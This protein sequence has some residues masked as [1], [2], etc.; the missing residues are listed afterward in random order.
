M[1]IEKSEY[2][3]GSWFASSMVNGV[4]FVGTSTDKIK[5]MQNCFAKIKWYFGIE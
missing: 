1:L 2:E 3:V 4:Y 5:A